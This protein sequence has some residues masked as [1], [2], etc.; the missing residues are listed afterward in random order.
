MWRCVTQIKRRLHSRRFIRISICGAYYH[1][2][3]NFL[4]LTHNYPSRPRSL[5]FILLRP[6]SSHRSNRIIITLRPVLR[7]EGRRRWRRRW[8]VVWRPEW[9]FQS[10][11]RWRISDTRGA[12]NFPRRQIQFPGRY[13]HWMLFT[14]RYENPRGHLVETINEAAGEHSFW[15]IRVDSFSLSLLFSHPLSATFLVLEFYIFLKQNIIVI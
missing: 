6:S 12:S 5:P 8:G 11:A 10:R 7:F 1:C 13:S 4:R 9:E 15:H 14:W 2:R 3:T